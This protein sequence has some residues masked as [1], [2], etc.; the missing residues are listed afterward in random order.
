[1]ELVL[2]TR[3]TYDHKGTFLCRRN[4]SCKSAGFQTPLGVT[5]ALTGNQADQWIQVQPRSELVGGQFPIDKCLAA[6]ILGKVRQNHPMKEWYGYATAYTKRDFPVVRA[7]CKCKSACSA[8]ELSS[9]RSD[10]FSLR[11]SHEL[12][13]IRISHMRYRSE[14]QPLHLGLLCRDRGLTK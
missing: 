3:P 5:Y 12:G 8:I 7:Y 6:V 1:M 11:L 10:P 2:R 9:R 14:G 4:S 13:Q